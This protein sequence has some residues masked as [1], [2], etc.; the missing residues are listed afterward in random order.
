MVSNRSVDFLPAIA[1][2]MPLP[3]VVVMKTLQ[4]LHALARLEKVGYATSAAAS[5]DTQRVVGYAGMLF[6]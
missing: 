2:V 3:A 6:A 5:G 1:S 4:R